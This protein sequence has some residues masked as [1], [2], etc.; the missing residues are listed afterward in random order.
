MPSFY[1]NYGWHFNPI[2]GI[3]N[4]SDRQLLKAKILFPVRNK[5]PAVT[6]NRDQATNIVDPKY[7]IDKRT[8]NQTANEVFENHVY[9]IKELRNRP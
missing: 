8:D 1:Y 5:N 6:Q 9:N 4:I 7:N 3:C 2:G